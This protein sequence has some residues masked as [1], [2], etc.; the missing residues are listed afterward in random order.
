MR[1]Q[2]GV[3]EGDGQ[4]VAGRV[5]GKDGMRGV[6]EAVTVASYATPNGV[7]L[8]TVAANDLSASATTHP[9]STIVVMVFVPMGPPTGETVA[10]QGSNAAIAFHVCRLHIPASILDSRR[11]RTV[12]LHFRR[13]RVRNSLISYKVASN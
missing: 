2:I 12:R 1:N 7:V 5:A 10:T 9:D 11:V 3:A 4:D 6:L 13:S 8:G